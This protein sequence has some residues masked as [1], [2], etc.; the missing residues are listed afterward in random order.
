[1]LP[2]VFAGEPIGTGVA[3]GEEPIA[4][5]FVVFIPDVVIPL[6]FIPE[7]DEVFVI[8]API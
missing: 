6:L 1:M 4:D 5:E 2:L 8:L 7:L 3:A